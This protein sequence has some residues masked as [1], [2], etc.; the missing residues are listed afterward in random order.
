MNKDYVED[1][2]FARVGG[3]AVDDGTQVKGD[4]VLHDQD[5]VELYM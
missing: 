3:S 2:K 5:V 1:L 4:Y